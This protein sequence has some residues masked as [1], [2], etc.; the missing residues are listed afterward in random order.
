MCSEAS[1]AL[2]NSIMSSVE[3]REREAEREA[4][5]GMLVAISGCTR[6]W[7]EALVFVGR[8]GAEPWDIAKLRMDGSSAQDSPSLAPQALSGTSGTG[9]GMREEVEHSC[10]PG[11]TCD[12]A[13][14]PLD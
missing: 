11:G 8:A 3:L 4:G 9:C 12:G 13:A 10:A 7:T 6:E 14:V 5:E 1:R 2:I